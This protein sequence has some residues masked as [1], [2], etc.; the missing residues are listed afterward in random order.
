MA[1][2]KENTLFTMKDGEVVSGVVRYESEKSIIL[3]LGVGEQLLVRSPD[4]VFKTYEEITIKLLNFGLSVNSTM[5]EMISEDVDDVRECN[6]LMYENLLSR[7]EK[8]E[9]RKWWNL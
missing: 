2:K 6:N 4:D 5:I 3:D 7:I 1:K 9:E 8:L